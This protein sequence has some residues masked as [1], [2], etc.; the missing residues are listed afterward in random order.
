MAR[1]IINNGGNGNQTQMAMPCFQGHGDPNNISNGLC[2]NGYL[3]IRTTG[4]H[5]DT[6]GRS[7][8]FGRRGRKGRNQVMNDNIIHQC[9]CESMAAKDYGN[10][11]YGGGNGSKPVVDDQVMMDYC[12][13]AS[14]QN[15]VPIECIG[16]GT[17]AWGKKQRGGSFRR[18]GGH[19]QT[20]IDYCAAATASH[21]G[22]Q[23][24]AIPKECIGWGTEAWAKKQRGG[25]FRE[26]GRRT[27]PV[28]MS[29]GS[30]SF[31]DLYNS[32]TLPI[33]NS[34]DEIFYP[35]CLA[36]EHFMGYQAGQCLTHGTNKKQRGGS[37]MSRKRAMGGSMGSA[38]TC[39]PGQHM[40]PDGTCMMGEYHGA[41]GGYRKGGRTKPK[42]RRKM[43]SGGHMHKMD[44]KVVDHQ[45]LSYQNMPDGS[46]GFMRTSPPV[47]SNSEMIGPMGRYRT[48]MDR[49]SIGGGNQVMIPPCEACRRTDPNFPATCPQC[50]GWGTQAHG[51][52][53]QRGGSFKRRTGGGVKKYPHGGM[54]NRNGCGGPG[55]MPCG[56]QMRKGGGVRKL[57]E[58]GIGGSMNTHCRTITSKTECIATGG[59]H[60]NYDGPSCH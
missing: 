11:V 20:M 59:C 35:W 5:G 2:P 47:D 32:G 44:S 36:F 19:N 42:P 55:Q 50:A 43:H 26:R 41:S 25:S 33:P 17:E 9:H 4:T 24:N 51:S 40:M 49:Q 6:K 45:H 10:L 52:K 38:G 46:E 56:G 58:G 27:R 60:W 14:M 53:K 1:R 12:A 57:H 34:N 7:A 30:K 54:H 23:Q 39:P 3:A 18:R 16:W 13:W 29:N 22:N 31:A 28:P 21:T 37:F 8:G 15:P 48:Q